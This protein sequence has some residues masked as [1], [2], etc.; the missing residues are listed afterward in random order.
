MFQTF[1][2]SSRRPRQVNLS[3]QNPNPFAASTWNS[4]ASASG[5]QKTV[6]HAQQEREQRQ[7][8]RE[9]LNASKKIQRVWRGHRSRTKLADARREQ[10]KATY[11]SCEGGNDD[12]VPLEQ[13]KLLMAF[14]NPER[15]D[16]VAQLTELGRK[17][18]HN[19]N[20]RLISQ[21]EYGPYLFKLARLTLSALIQYVCPQYVCH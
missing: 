4:S 8:E 1:S 2:G 14:C 20:T 16:D 19:K 15:D 11:T 17:F 7:R 18:V 21:E 10:Y 6:A 9:R 12:L 3:G 13:L 5:A